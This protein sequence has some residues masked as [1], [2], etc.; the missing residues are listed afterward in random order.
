MRF[1]LITLLTIITLP[2]LVNADE[3]AAVKNHELANVL[4][5]FEVVAEAKFP[6]SK[7]MYVRVIK[8][9]DQ[10][11]CD[12]SLE[13]CPQSILYIAVSS[14]DEAPDQKVFQTPK[15]YNWKFDGWDKLPKT[16]KPTDYVQLRLSAQKPSKNPSNTWQ[17]EHYL[18][19]LNYHDG[20]WLKQ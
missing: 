9:Q 12:G 13:S 5:N 19:K 3:L 16:D 6:E 20:S 1:A 4:V 8:V 11:E 14:Y 17:D 18:Y 2:N 10:G 7:G 15:G